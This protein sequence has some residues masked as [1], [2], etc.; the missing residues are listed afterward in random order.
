MKKFEKLLLH[1]S[2]FSSRRF[3]T[4]QQKTPKPSVKTLLYEKIECRLHFSMQVGEIR[5]SSST[6][7]STLGASRSKEMYFHFPFTPQGHNSILFPVP[8]IFCRTRKLKQIRFVLSTHQFTYLHFQSWF[9]PV[10]FSHSLFLLLKELVILLFWGLIQIYISFATKYS[11]GHRAPTKICF[12][13]VNP[14]HKWT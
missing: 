8:F 5:S 10:I 12:R 13:R 6:F 11:F 14:S 2:N 9:S 1:K 3:S 7:S 4:Y